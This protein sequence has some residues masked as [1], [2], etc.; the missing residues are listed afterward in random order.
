MGRLQGPSRLDS[1]DF[2]RDG[3]DRSLASSAIFINVSLACTS[4]RAGHQSP[5]VSR[6][7][8]RRSHE[9]ALSVSRPRFARLHR[10]RVRADR[11]RSAAQQR[12]ALH[13][14]RGSR[15]KPACDLRAVDRAHLV[16]DLRGSRRWGSD[17]R[18]RGD[19][20]RWSRRSG[21]PGR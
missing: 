16:H 2:H 17:D 1:G 18:R 15:R 6:P 20:V 5:A 9:E 13:Q 14:C 12:S 10:H 3:G 7:N 21:R 4:I 11:L 19:H 8:L